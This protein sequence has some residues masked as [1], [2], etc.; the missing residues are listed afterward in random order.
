MARM[1]MAKFKPTTELSQDADGQDAD[2]QDADDNGQN[3]N[4]PGYHRRAFHLDLN[5]FDRNDGVFKFD[6]YD[7]RNPITSLSYG[8]GSIFMITDPFEEAKQRTALYYQFPDD[9][10][11]MSGDFNFNFWH[12]V[13]A[14]DSWQALFKRQNIVRNL[15]QNE[16]D[17]ANRVIKG[18]MTER[19]NVT[20]RWVES[21]YKRCPYQPKPVIVLRLASGR[22]V[23]V[24]LRHN[25]YTLGHI[26]RDILDDDIL[27][28]LRL[29]RVFL[30]IPGSN[31]FL[32]RDEDLRTL[33]PNFPELQVVV[34]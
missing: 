15:P 9:A 1:L 11:I 20:I 6:R 14:V 34:C 5:K 2:G 3:E 27:G 28:P 13:P 17:E 33:L 29:N 25:R 18:E 30:L 7:A 12:G 31:E 10:I 16:F 32:R 22:G 23:R 4:Q 19:F 26:Q 8:R 24:L 21:H